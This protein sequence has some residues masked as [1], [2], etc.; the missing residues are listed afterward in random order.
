[1]AMSTAARAVLGIGLLGLTLAVLN[2]A[3]A[4]SLDPPLE[5][6]AV[7]ASLLAVVLM[8]VGLLWT[9]LDPPAAARSELVGRQGLELARGLPDP[10]ARELAWGSRMLLTATP[11]A[12]L[13]L[14]W[15]GATLL[16]RGLLGEEPFQA[17][18]ICGRCLERQ[19]VIS[20]VDLRLYPGREEFDGLLPGLPSVVVQPIGT[21]GILVLGGWSPRCF[22]R[23]DLLWIDGWAGRLTTEWAQELDGVGQVSEDPNASAPGTD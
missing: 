11:A 4:P 10:L 7:L 19:Q 23:S 2:Q 8:L 21:R 6:S 3:T 9:R 5:R 22:S 17:G 16:R 14:Q 13:L 20:L 18:A 1:M 15:Q 12:V